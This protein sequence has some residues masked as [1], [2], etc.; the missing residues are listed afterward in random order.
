[1]PPPAGHPTCAWPVSHEAVDEPLSLLA[2]VQSSALKLKFK[3]C[4]SLAPHL[5]ALA[6]LGRRLVP[7]VEALA[8]ALME[9]C[10]SHGQPAGKV[11]PTDWG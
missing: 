9:Y 3:A 5:P 1:M 2:C 10:D 8:G 7:K 6:A 4:N 11:R